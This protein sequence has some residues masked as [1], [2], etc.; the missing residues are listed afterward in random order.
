MHCRVRMRATFK[1]NVNLDG[2]KGFM[3]VECIWE[4]LESG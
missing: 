2:D 1:D 3:E 4:H